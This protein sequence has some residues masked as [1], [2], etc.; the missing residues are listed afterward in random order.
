MPRSERRARIAD[1]RCSVS[2][3]AL[4]DVVHGQLL[5]D[6]LVKHRR[7]GRQQQRVSQSVSSFVS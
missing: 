2:S 5:A 6:R 3:D 7:R 4:R 1:S